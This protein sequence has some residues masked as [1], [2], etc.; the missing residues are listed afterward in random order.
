MA[1]AH[2]PILTRKTLPSAPSTTCCFHLSVYFVL[3]EE[4]EE[5][6]GGGRRDGVGTGMERKRLPH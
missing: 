1:A 5:E 3:K 4:E 6:E 2:T